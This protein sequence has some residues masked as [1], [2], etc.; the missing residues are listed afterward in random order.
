[1]A[2][3][4]P[5]SP[6]VHA[7]ASEAAPAFSLAVEKSP[8]AVNPMSVIDERVVIAM[9]G[10]PA[11][12]KSY[13]SKAIVH[14]LTFLGCPVQLFNAGNK[15]RSQGLAGADASFFDASNT[16]AK[17]VRDRMA[18]ETLDDLLEW[19]EAV[20]A[21]CGC[22]IFDATNTTVA[23]RRAVIE[24]CARAEQASSRSLRLVFV[25][26]VC[27]DEAV[28]RHSYRLKL[29]N[30]DYA[31][32]D[33][34]AGLADFLS[35]VAEYEKIY[36][37]ITDDEAKGFEAEY[38]TNGGRLRYV[39]TV[40]AGRRLIASGCNSYLMSHVVSLLHV[41]HLYPRKISLLLAGQSENDASGIRGGDTHLSPAGHAYAK[42]LCQLVRERGTIGEAP[43][44]IL[45]G[46][47][48]RYAQVADHL[49]APVAANAANAR[50]WDRAPAR[51]QLK[52][53]NE[54]RR[55]SP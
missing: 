44:Q 10:L 13:I 16:D 4:V 19:L 30:G 52:A 39:Q 46:T 34:E 42:S 18:M 37:T 28:L 31:G 8:Y 5:R 48:R 36:E 20:P 3:G 22:G 12:G 23:R 9:V 21:G 7:C 14:Y 50:G 53:L 54:V 38:D 17:Q 47:L 25:E 6:G 26:S 15:R 29:A 11:R 41:I 32:A 55:R 49:C 35:R 45:L 2:S 51:L 24:R 33:P 40:N 43:P 1:M 27:D